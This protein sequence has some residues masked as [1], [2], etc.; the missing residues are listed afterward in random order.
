MGAD[1]VDLDTRSNMAANR[2]AMEFIEMF[3]AQ[4]T[5]QEVRNIRRY[6]THLILCATYIRVVTSFPFEAGSYVHCPLLTLLSCFDG[7]YNLH[8]HRQ[9]SERAKYSYFYILWSLKEA[10]IKAIGQGLGYNLKEVLFILCICIL[11]LCAF[12]LDTPAITDSHYSYAPSFEN[13]SFS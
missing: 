7:I 13:F 6:V 9:S 1:I 5:D 12:M 3:E 8:V 4:L 10:F 2:G 11:M